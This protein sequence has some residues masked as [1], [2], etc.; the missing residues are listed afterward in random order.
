MSTL[1][2]AQEELKILRQRNQELVS[3]RDIA[4]TQRDMNQA[5]LKAVRAEIVASLSE[6]KKLLDDNAKLYSRMCDLEHTAA[7]SK[8]QTSSMNSRPT[9]SSITVQAVYVDPENDTRSDARSR[10]QIPYTHPYYSHPYY[11]NYVNC[12]SEN[13]R[14]DEETAQTEGPE[15]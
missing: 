11:A 12:Y 4:R 3:E 10:T 7:K 9:T 5:H 2:A 8:V 13:Y 15:T 6:I 1:E 14:T